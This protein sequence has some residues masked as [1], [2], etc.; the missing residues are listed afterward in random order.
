[1]N[2]NRL[3]SVESVKKICTDHGLDPS[4]YEPTES[5]KGLRDTTWDWIKAIQGGGNP[6]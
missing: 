5:E 4:K 6:I 2:N 1:V 3:L